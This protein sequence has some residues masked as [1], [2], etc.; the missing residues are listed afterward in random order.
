MGVTASTAGV[1]ATSSD[2]AGR[3]LIARWNG[4]SWRRMPVPAQAGTLEGV[5]A[6]AAH[7][8]WAVGT[9]GIPS[10]TGTQHS[11]ILRWNG[12]RWNVVPS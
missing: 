12:G 4:R 10:P 5:T 7:G 11:V 6:T 8:G 9:R 2:N 3:F 1:W